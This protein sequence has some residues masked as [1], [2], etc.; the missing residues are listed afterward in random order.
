VRERRRVRQM[1]LK[2]YDFSSAGVWV[3]MCVHVCVCVCE[4]HRAGAINEGQSL[5]G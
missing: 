2:R 1:V 3:C 5:P 4:A